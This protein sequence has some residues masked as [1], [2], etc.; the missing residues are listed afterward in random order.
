MDDIR[1]TLDLIE[2]MEI[3]PEHRQALKMAQKIR[4]Y[5]NDPG[6]SAATDDVV[7]NQMA[8]LGTLLSKVGAD[9]GPK[10]LTDVLK[11]MQQY[12]ADRNQEEFTV[13]R[14]KELISMASR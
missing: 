6:K 12:A 9:F 7:Y 11:L 1:K 4:A 14:F 10:S 3:K 13:D 8:E 5:I 2:S